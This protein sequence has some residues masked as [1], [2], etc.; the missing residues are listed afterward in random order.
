MISLNVINAQ[1]IC[2]P[3]GK[4]EDFIDHVTGGQV[5]LCVVTETF[6]TEQNNVTRVA[7][8][9]SGYTFKDQPRSNSKARG[10]TGIFHQESFQVCK[11]SHGE[12]SSF[13][14][15]EW[16]VSWHNY[17]VRLCIIYHQP[18]SASHPITDATF[19]HDFES[20]LDTIVLVDEMLCITGDFNL[21]ID[22]PTDTYGCQFNDLLS[23]Y[24]LVNHITFPTHQASHTLDLVITWNNQEMELRSIKLGYFLSDHCFVCVE[25][26]IAKPDVQN[27]ILSYHKIKSIDKASFT[28]DL[29]S[30]C[31][32]LLWTDDLNELAAQYN[33]RLLG[34]QDKHAPVTTKTLSVHPK[35]PWFSPAINN[36]KRERRKAE[37]EWRTVMLNPVSC[38]KFQA[39][40]NRYRY[41][42]LAAKCS[43]FSDTIIEAKGDQ[44]KIYSIIKSLTAVKSDIPMPHHIWTQQLADNFGQFFIKKIEDIRSELNAPDNPHLPKSS[45]FNNYYFT[46]FG[47]LTHNDVRKLIT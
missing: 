23:S 4:T 12:K 38:S 11:L 21:H 40:R 29:D 15:S 31:Q 45:S 3:S 24:G 26:V 6:L 32:D 22:D 1:S 16:H 35:V 10:G 46:N 41:S 44:K 8:H 34:L 9:P 28:I 25:I 43:F 42:L 7:L 5:D 27:K 30:I 39:A 19:M 18:Y 20:Y 14:Y 2:G 13:E 47:Q 36:L 33:C 37:R 17:C